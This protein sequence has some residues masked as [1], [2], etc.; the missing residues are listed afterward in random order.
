MTAALSDL[1]APLEPQLEAMRTVLARELESE[2][3]AVAAML[4]HLSRFRG[5]QLRATLLLLMGQAS[6]NDHHVKL[7]PAMT[8]FGRCRAFMMIV[9]QFLSTDDDSPGKDVAA[10]IFGIG[11]SIPPPVAHSI[12]YTSS[13][14]RNP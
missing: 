12:D 6:G 4:E 2:D 14:E 1:L 3:P 8:E 9:M 10:A 13:P 11:V 7:P 5:K